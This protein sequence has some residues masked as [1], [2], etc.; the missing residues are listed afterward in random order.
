MT[1]P[2]VRLIYLAD[3]RFPLERANG[4]QTM[5]TCAALTE[6][7]HIVDLIVRPDTTSPARN[8]FEYYAVTRTDRFRIERV[9]ASGPASSRRF[10]YL[11]FFGLPLFVKLV[12]L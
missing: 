8:P 7:G 10:R 12:S 9:P 6:R 3:I 5:E 11:A 1:A 4:I 2:L